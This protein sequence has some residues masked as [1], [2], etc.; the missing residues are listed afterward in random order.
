[1]PWCSHPADRRRCGHRDSNSTQAP[2]DGGEGP[3]RRW[4]RRPIL[5]SAARAV[6]GPSPSRGQPR[7]S[8]R[9]PNPYV[10]RD[11]RFTRAARQRC[12][13]IDAQRPEIGIEA[14]ADARAEANVLRSRQAALIGLAGIEEWDDSEIAEAIARLDR[15]LVEAAPAD[16]LAGRVA[17]AQFLVTEAAYRSA[18]TAIIAARRREI[19]AGNAVDRAGAAPPCHA[20]A[21]GDGLI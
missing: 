20:E 1:M 2:A 3:G 19:V 8:K 21:I 9:L 18:T 12:G 16:R 14:P 10:K 4:R 7:P 6:G 17:R 15:R 5:R 11:L 13:D